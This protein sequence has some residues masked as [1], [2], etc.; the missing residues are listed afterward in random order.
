MPEEETVFS[1][2]IKQ[3][4]VFSFK[5][6][7]KFCYD[8]LAEET[9]LSLVEDS[10]GEKIT[11]TNKEIDVKWTGTRKVTD[12]F[13]FKVKV[14]FVVRELTEVE[15]I[16]EGIKVK[17][18]KGSVQVKVKGILIRDYQGKFE[19]TAIQKFMRSIY[20]KW[21]IPSR[22]DEFERRLINNCDEFLGQA[23]AY[24]DLEGRK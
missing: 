2:A 1:S 3:K 15:V 8:W 23:K 10:Y 21:I 14:D 22:I 18:N 13:K 20:E 4:G 16:Q 24:L 6:F 11:G 19:K 17:T 7:Y 12:Y 9:N 5:D